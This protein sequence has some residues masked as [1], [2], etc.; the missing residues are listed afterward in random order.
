MKEDAHNDN[1]EPTHLFVTS[2]SA[3][4]S[5]WVRRA[6]CSNLVSN[7]Y[8]STISHSCTLTHRSSIAYTHFGVAD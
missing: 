8:S 2:G 4:V 3:R 7:Q 6:S 1:F 5:G